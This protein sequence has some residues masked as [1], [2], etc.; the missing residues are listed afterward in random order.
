MTT[1]ALTGVL[2][3]HIDVTVLA[4][5]PAG[6]GSAGNET[7]GALVVAVVLAILLLGGAL[8]H[9]GRAFAPIGE[10]VRMVLSA[11]AVAA[12]LIGTIAVLIALVV[13]TAGRQ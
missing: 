4:G 10:L 12:L 2:V 8:K 1:L 11:L 9:L 5:P 6:T 3:N 13:F 7:T